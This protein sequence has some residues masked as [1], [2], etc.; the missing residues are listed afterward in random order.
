MRESHSLRSCFCLSLRIAISILRCSGLL[1]RRREVAAVEASESG[2]NDVF[3]VRL[4]FIILMLPKA[5][6]SFDAKGIQASLP[7]VE[8]VGVPTCV[9][10]VEFREIPLPGQRQYGRRALSYYVEDLLLT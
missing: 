7:G 6:I 4:M 1:D 8:K 2:I 9:R 10:T 3:L 5:I